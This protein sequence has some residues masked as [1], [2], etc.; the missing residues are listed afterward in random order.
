MIQ[1]RIKFSIK[2]RPAKETDDR[3]FIPPKPEG[4]S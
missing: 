1:K 3:W 4:G 2:I